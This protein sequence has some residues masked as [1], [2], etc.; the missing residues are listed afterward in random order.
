VER[1]EKGKIIM[2]TKTERDKQ[3]TAIHTLVLQNWP[4]RDKYGRARPMRVI[5]S[6]ESG[7]YSNWW[8]DKTSWGFDPAKRA[9]IT[10]LLAAKQAECMDWQNEDVQ[11]SPEARASFVLQCLTF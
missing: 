2:G 9:C 10:P 1:E 6:N 5:E 8:G 3:I 7:Y 11:D 4:N